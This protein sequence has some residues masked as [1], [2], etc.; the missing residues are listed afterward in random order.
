MNTPLFRCFCDN[1]FAVPFCHDS[2]GHIGTHAVYVADAAATENPVREY[3]QRVRMEAAK[4]CFELSR[5]NIT[6]VMYAV[7]YSDEKTFRELFK[8]IIGVAP[9]D[10]RARYQKLQAA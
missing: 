4:R 2:H 9:A 1:V 7:G 8:K 10:Y 3:L 6:E 5:K